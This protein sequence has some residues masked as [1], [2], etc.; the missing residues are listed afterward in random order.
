MP[1][2]PHYFLVRRIIGT[3][4]KRLIHLFPI[5][6]QAL[7]ISSRRIVLDLDDCDCDH[8]YEV[9]RQLAKAESKARINDTAS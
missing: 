5:F 1:L 2:N 7:L 6:Q 4:G 8:D 3:P 9:L